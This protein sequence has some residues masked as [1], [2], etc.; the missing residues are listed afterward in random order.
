[1]L[2]LAGLG[3]AIPMGVAGFWSAGCLVISGM[4][5]PVGLWSVA[6]IYWAT[7]T[8]G[9]ITLSQLEGSEFTLQPHRAAPGTSLRL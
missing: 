4:M 7:N 3:A 5:P 8:A 1:V 6:S 2:L 9:T